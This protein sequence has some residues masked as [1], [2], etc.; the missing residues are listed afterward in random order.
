MRVL[1]SCCHLTPPTAIVGLFKGRIIA[2]DG[3]VSGHPAIALPAGLTDTGL[4]VGFQN[5]GKHF[6]EQTVYRVAY[7]FEAVTPWPHRHLLSS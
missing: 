1:P 4:P 3:H 5:I 7:A 6:D 2:D